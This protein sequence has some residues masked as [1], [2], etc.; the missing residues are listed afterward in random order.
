MRSGE[1]SGPSSGL[2]APPGG[3]WSALCEG[4]GRPWLGG[5]TPGSYLF[6]VWAQTSAHGVVRHPPEWSEPAQSAS[7]SGV[8]AER[9]LGEFRKGD[10]RWQS[11][12]TLVTSQ[13]SQ[14]ILHMGVF[15]DAWFTPAC[16]VLRGV[17]QGLPR[18][19][20]QVWHFPRGCQKTLPKCVASFHTYRGLRVVLFPHILDSIVCFQ[21]NR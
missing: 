19:R 11:W 7:G 9:A 20:V 3:L 13:V 12:R 1:G 5:L 14:A 10:H 4:E 16:R 15:T 8:G 17:G 2:A 18:Q 21:L 6:K